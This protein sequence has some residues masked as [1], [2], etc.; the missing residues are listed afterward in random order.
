MDWTPRQPRDLE[1]EG[2]GDK[3]D[4]RKVFEDRIRWI[5]HHGNHRKDDSKMDLD[6]LNF[7]A[8]RLER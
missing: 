4:G 7:G 2:F 3:L 6:G 5:V 1:R 8:V